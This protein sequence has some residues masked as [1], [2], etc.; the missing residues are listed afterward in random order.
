MQLYATRFADANVKE[1]QF[2]HRGEKRYSMINNESYIFILNRKADPNSDRGMYRTVSNIEELHQQAIK[3]YG[4]AVHPVVVNIDDILGTMDE[5]IAHF[6]HI[7]I[8]VAPHG[9]NLGNVAFL[10]AGAAVLEL[11]VEGHRQHAMMFEA[12]AKSYDL[13]Y[14]VSYCGGA[15]WGDGP[16]QAHLGDK[17][18]KGW[19]PLWKTLERLLRETEAGA[20]EEARIR[21]HNNIEVLSKLSTRPAWSAAADPTC[22]T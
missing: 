12:V 4:K 10:P 17:P 7:R 11:G 15:H 6:R 13:R 2:P 16:I 5:T 8:L 20:R 1:T 19:P 3:R 9:A 21:V 14:G 18:I 22:S